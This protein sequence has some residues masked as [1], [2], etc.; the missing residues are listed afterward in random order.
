MISLTLSVCLSIYL[1]TCLC[2]CPFY[3]DLSV[4]VCRSVNDIILHRSNFDTNTSVA[5][6]LHLSLC[7]S[8]LL[9]LCLFPFFFRFFS[10]LLFPCL[11]FFFLFFSFSLLTYLSTFCVETVTLLEPKR[12]SFYSSQCSS[13][14]NFYST[15]VLSLI[16][17]PTKKSKTRYRKKNNT[18]RHSLYFLLNNRLDL[19]GILYRYHPVI[20]FSRRKEKRTEITRSHRLSPTKSRAEG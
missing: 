5:S 16:K 6:S 1:S 13:R 17:I 9:V 10:P 12:W 2:V 18:Y 20:R 11:S 8:F 14:F 4:S 15:V 19:I 3:L 7:L